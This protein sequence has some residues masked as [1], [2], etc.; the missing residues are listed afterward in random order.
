MIGSTFMNKA[1]RVAFIGGIRI[2]NVK[3]QNNQH[4]MAPMPRQCDARLF[5]LI[6]IVEYSFMGPPAA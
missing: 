2:V 6:N 1:P 4:S 5:D 3:I